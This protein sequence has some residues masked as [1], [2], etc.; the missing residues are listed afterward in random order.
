MSKRLSPSDAAALFENYYKFLIE[1]GGKDSPTDNPKAKYVDFYG[2]LEIVT[3][4][5]QFLFGI[6]E[7]EN[8]KLASTVEKLFINKFREMGVIPKK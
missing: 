1:N 7:A 5:G 3:V 8:P 6:H 2:T 4:A